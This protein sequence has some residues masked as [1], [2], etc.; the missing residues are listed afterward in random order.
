M[1]LIIYVS[2]SYSIL[3]YKKPIHVRYDVI[4]ANMKLLQKYNKDIP[5]TWEELIETGKY[6]KEHENDNSLII[7]N[8]LFPSN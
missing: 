3:L 4:Y 2:I 1:F 5:K 7:Y 8:G 6:I